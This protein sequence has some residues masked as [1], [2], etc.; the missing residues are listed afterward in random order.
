MSKLNKNEQGFG[1]VEAILVLVIGVLIGVVGWFAWHNHNK[2]TPTT[3]TTTTSV[4]TTPTT[5]TKPKPVDPYA[6]WETYTVAEDKTISFRYPSDWK[7]IS[8]FY[9]SSAKPNERYVKLTAPTLYH[10]NDFVV[11]FRYS[12]SSLNDLCEPG[13][14]PSSSVVKTEKLTTSGKD[15]RVITVAGKVAGIT[16]ISNRLV[17]SSN[18]SVAVPSGNI[19]IEEHLGSQSAPTYNLDLSTYSSLAESK[20]IDSMLKSIKF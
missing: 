6:G 1:A 16:T 10:N 17:D 15:L 14:I 8:N 19:V 7:V 3:T 20:T 2:T 4:T 5:T 12:T 11:I 9:D 13:G 18:C